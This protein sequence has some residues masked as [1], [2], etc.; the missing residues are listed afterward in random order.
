VKLK[1]LTGQK[2]N[3]WTV[4]EYAGKSYWNCRCECGKEKAVSGGSLTSGRTHSCGCYAVEQHTTHGMSKTRVYKIWESMHSRC[5]RQ[6]SAYWHRYGGR[7]IKVCDRWR[8]FENFYN[9]MGNPPNK[10]HSIG[11]IDNDGN[12]EPS[13]ARWETSEQQD[14][15]K[16]SNRKVCIDGVKKT[17]TQWAKQNG[18]NPSTAISRVF[19]GWD[20]VDAVT[21]PVKKG[22]KYKE[23]AA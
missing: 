19:Y 11:R 3:R 18:I 1:D 14:N 13:N 5:E 7:G 20:E 17:V 6:T 10:K 8:S 15:N 23:H 16:I 9:D 22:W 12:Y 2:F 4:L 21:L